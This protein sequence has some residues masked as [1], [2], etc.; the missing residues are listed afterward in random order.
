MANSQS[1][2]GVNISNATKDESIKSIK[3]SQ[4]HKNLT[5]KAR[6]KVKLGKTLTTLRIAN[7]EWID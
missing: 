7:V 1:T 3:K 6:K 5:E 4:G 2:G